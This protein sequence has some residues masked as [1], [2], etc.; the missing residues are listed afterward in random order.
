MYIPPTRSESVFN[1]DSSIRMHTVAVTTLLF[2]GG[3]LP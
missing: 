3:H 2:L 1:G